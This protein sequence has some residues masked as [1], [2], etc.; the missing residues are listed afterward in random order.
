VRTYFDGA[1]GAQQTTFGQDELFA[2]DAEATAR[3][4][5]VLHPLL[6]AAGLYESMRVD[7]KSVVDGE[8]AFVLVLTPKQGA[9]VELY[10]SAQSGRVVRRDRAGESVRY[11]DFR[12]VDGE[13]VPF[14]ST[15]RGP[16]GD[17]VLVVKQL[18]FGGGG[19]AREGAAREGAARGGAAREG[20]ARAGSVP[21]QTF[22]PVAKLAR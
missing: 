19:A 8:E 22:G 10:V 14:A 13:L 7:R 21:A 9:P 20:A 6:E 17:K 1:H 15:E 4:D 16:L 12:T 3:R 2:G 18:R 5:A 11:S